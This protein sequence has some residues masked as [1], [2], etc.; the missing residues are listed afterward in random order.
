MS[1]P[2]TTRLDVKLIESYGH[3]RQPDPK[4]LAALTDEQMQKMGDSYSWR[5]YFLSRGLRAA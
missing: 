2:G 3:L 1:A 4:S 5:M